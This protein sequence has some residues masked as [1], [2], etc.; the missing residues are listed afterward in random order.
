MSEEAKLKEL[1]KEHRHNRELRRYSAKR[2]NNNLHMK[3]KTRE[4]VETQYNGALLVI[5]QLQKN[6]DLVSEDIEWLKNSV[7]DYEVALNKVIALM[8]DSILFKTWDYSYEELQVLIENL[9]KL[10]DEVERIHFR[11]MCQD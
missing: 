6:Y 4:D 1:L 10:H 2:D 11:K 3:I 7:A 5:E 8:T 9:S